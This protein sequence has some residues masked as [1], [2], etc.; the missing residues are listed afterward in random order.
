MTLET[1]VLPD[2]EAPGA[3]L[4]KRGGDHGDADRGARLHDLLPQSA[5]GQIIWPPMY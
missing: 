4:R 1:Q 2:E 5:G 3:L